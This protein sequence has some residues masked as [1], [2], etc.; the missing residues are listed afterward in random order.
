MN[1]TA[2]ISYKKRTVPSWSWMAYSGG[3]AFIADAMQDR[4]VPHRVDLGFTEDGEALNVKVRK[5]VGDCR[6]EDRGEEYAIVDGTQQVGSLWFDV[7]DQIQLK[8]YSCA[9]VSMVKDDKKADA[10]KT[11]YVL[12]IRKKAWRRGYKRAG[13]GKVEAQYVSRECVAGTLR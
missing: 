6:M 10:R 12:V 9:V 8:D 7:A 4:R 13:V 3:I 1:K 5:F 11:Y 2:R